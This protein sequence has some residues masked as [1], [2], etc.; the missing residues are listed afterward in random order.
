MRLVD[1]CIT[2]FEYVCIIDFTIGIADVSVVSVVIVAVSVDHTCSYDPDTRSTDVS[3]DA[4]S[5][6]SFQ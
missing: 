4:V 1:I 6:F 5:H 2:L 3:S